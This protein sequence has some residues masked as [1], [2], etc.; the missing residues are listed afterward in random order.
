ML[1]IRLFKILCENLGESGNSN[2]NFKWK[3]T[4]IIITN[5]K[6]RKRT[7]K[8]FDSELEENDGV[9]SN[10]RH[11]TKNVARID[12]EQIERADGQFFFIEARLERDEKETVVFGQLVPF[13]AQQNIDGCFQFT[14]GQRQMRHQPIYEN[15]S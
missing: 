9:G 14:A 1:S 12:G 7:L 6:H 15:G 4:S 8:W 2:M 11:H 3:H 5:I 10:E 13:A